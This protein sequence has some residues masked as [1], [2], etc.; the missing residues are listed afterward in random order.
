V[1][2]KNRE[3]DLYPEEKKRREKG[4]R[5]ALSQPISST[6]QRKNAEDNYVTDDPGGESHRRG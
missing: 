6:N 5:E 4:E 2:K 1:E 3:R